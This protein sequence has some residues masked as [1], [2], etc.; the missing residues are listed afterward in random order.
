M[1]TIVVN[2]TDEQA[3]RLAVRAAELHLT[4]QESVQEIILQSL[5]QSSLLYDKPHKSR[6]GWAEAFQ[7]MHDNGDD[8]LLIEDYKT[9]HAEDRILTE[10]FELTTGD[11]I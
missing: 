2:I 4:V 11:S 5:E 8:A 3:N 1:Q 10:N 9:T 6:E 7:R